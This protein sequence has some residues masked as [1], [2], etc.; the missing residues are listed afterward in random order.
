MNSLLYKIEENNPVKCLSKLLQ[1]VFAEVLDKNI[2][3]L[4]LYKNFGGQ[5]RNYKQIDQKDS[6][7]SII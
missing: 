6:K 7:I 3:I 4:C 1:E 5:V 2:L